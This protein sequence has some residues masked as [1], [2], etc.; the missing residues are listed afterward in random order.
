[1]K[2]GIIGTGFIIREALTAMSEVP[3]IALGAIFARPGSVQKGQEFAEEFGIE[4][5]YTDYDEL[6][7][8]PEIDTVYVANINL[9]HYEYGKKALL[10]GRDVIMEKPFVTLA[11]H[12]QELADLAESR[13]LFIF[14]AVTT[15]NC[16]IMEKMRELL[17]GIGRVR[18]IQANYSQYSSRYDRYLRGD[19]APAFDPA[20]CGGALYDLNVY[21]FNMAVA[22]FGPPAEVSY[23]PNY[24]FNGI[25]T[26]GIA[27]LRYEDFVGVLSAAKDSDSP[28]HF[29]VQGERGWIQ[30]PGKP[31]ESERLR[32]CIDK[33]EGE[34][35]PVPDK[36]RMVQEFRNF[37]RAAAEKD[38]AFAERE[39]R[40]TLDVMRAI[41][42]ARLSAGIRFPSDPV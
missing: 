19:V 4:K 30:I 24:G 39:I 20:A 22:L 3:E 18:M 42:K 28:S 8:D 31:N 1:M 32:W 26:S 37:S 29:T 33:E 36:N 41:E 10:A 23:L 21:N 5:V 17:P 25:D 35:I 15:R 12:A 11:A 13:G 9:V 27:T 38:C 6:L 14:E 7:R 2:I 40:I 34:F 16:R